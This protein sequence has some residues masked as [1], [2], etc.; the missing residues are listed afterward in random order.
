LEAAY[1]AN[2][3]SWLKCREPASRK[4]DVIYH[5]L[6][7]ALS[8]TVGA[9]IE[10]PLRLDT[11]PNDLAAAVLAYRSQPVNGAFEAVERMG[12]AGCNH[13]EGEVVIVTADFT[14]SH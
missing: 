8:G 14:S 10:G 11:M 3:V 6:D 1:G 5:S 4:L 12:V 2:A 13:L 7:A 9:A